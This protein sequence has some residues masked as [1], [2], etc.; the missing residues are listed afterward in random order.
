[1]TEPFEDDDIGKLK[2]M[3]IQF[4]NGIPIFPFVPDEIK[5][6]R[7]LVIEAGDL[8]NEKD[9]Q[10]LIQRLWQGPEVDF[11]YFY[12]HIGG[13][14]ID[15]ALLGARNRGDILMDEME[16]R[17]YKHPKH[18]RDYLRIIPK[19]E[20]KYN[21]DWEREVVNKGPEFWRVT[22]KLSQ[23]KRDELDA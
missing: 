7:F 21:W 11:Y 4:H 23:R 15:T 6:S 2:K 17:Y 1:M 19:G 12:G 18:I 22:L 20:D 14:A 16:R 9:V 13:P 3:G 5:E 8:S 10:I